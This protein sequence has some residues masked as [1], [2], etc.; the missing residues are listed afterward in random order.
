M[1]ANFKMRLEIFNKKRYSNSILSARIQAVNFYWN[2]AFNSTLPIHTKQNVANS[3]LDDML[4]ILCAKI[5]CL[6]IKDIL[7]DSHSASEERI[8]S[9]LIV[10]GLVYSL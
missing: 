1:F 4:F 9:Q 3:N 8:S 2:S 10:I 6:M 5:L 7:Q